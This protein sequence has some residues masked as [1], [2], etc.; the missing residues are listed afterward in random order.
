[1][2]IVVI[3][4]THGDDEVARKIFLREEKSDVFLHAGDVVSLPNEIVPF[5]AVRGNCDMF[6]PQYPSHFEIETEYGKLY[7]Q[8]YPMSQSELNNLKKS[9]VKIFIHGHTH[10]K[11]IKEYDGITVLCPGSAS[12]PRDD[13]ESYMVI[14][15]YK[16]K[17][18]VQFKKV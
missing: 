10:V 11:E 18:D 14:T 9:G 4:D 8:H 1:M 17:I 15:T 13:Y 3:S 16:E 5:I 6:Y 12:R 7:I 2:R